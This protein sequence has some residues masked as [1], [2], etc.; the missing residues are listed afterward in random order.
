VLAVSLELFWMMSALLAIINLLPLRIGVLYTDGARM[1]ML[2]ITSPK[3]RR[4][5]S[6]TAIGNQSQ[7]G[8][9]AKLWNLDECRSTGWRQVNRRSCWQGVACAAAN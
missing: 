2:R 7:N 9:R 6:L 5:I 3:A 8:V 4:W 1:L